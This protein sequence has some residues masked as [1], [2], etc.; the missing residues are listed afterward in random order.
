[1]SELGSQWQLGAEGYPFRTA[2][3]VVLFDGRDRLL[4]TLGH[5]ADQ[6]ERHWWFTIG[7]GLEGE[8]TIQQAAL[9][10]VWEETGI[11]LASD[12]LVGP[13]LFRR[14]RFQFANVLA[15]QDEWF[16]IARTTSTHLVHTGWTDLERE[17][18]DE[19]RWWDLDDLENT[20]RTENLEIYPRDLIVRARAWLAGWDGQMAYLNE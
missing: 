9:R 2:A 10:E 5:D 1:M 8:E 11:R 20:C 6:P 7:G 3:R 13:V 17:V 12:A 16:F 14:A 15:R 18:L 19:Q 4:L